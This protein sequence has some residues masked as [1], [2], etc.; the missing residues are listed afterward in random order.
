[1]RR[2]CG[3]PPRGVRV[4][5]RRVARCG[6]VA[7]DVFASVV[8]YVEEDVG[9]AGDVGA[10]PG[11]LGAG[12]GRLGRLRDVRVRLER[13][14]TALGVELEVVRRSRERGRG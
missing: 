4:S 10:A 11:R 12:L 5:R 2:S 7:I 6:D 9:V 14:P 3:G 8:L 1:M 13:A